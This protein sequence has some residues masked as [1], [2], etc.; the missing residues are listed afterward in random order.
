MDQ[1]HSLESAVKAL[2]PPIF[3]KFE[4]SFKAQVS[5]W[6]GQK[7][8]NVMGKLADLEAQTKTTGAP[9]QTLCSQAILSLSMMR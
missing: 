9:V 7:L 8:D 4:Q 6:R 3:F 2:Q 1:G 5:K